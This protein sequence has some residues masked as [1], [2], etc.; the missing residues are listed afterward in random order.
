MLTFQSRGPTLCDGL[1]RREW[2]RIGGLSA[3]G[4]GLPQLQQARAASDTSL[5]SQK[6]VPSF[7]KAKSCIVLFLLGGPPQHETW[8]P[9]PDAPL[10]IRGDLKPIASATPGLQVGELMPLTSKLTNHIAVLRATATDD[11][12]HSSSGYAFPQKPR[13]R[14]S[15]CTQRLAQH[16][17]GGK[18]PEGRSRQPTWLHPLARGDLEYRKNCLAWPKCG[19]AG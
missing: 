12:A 7:G 4:I 10:E 15:R 6:L 3:F 1:S 9:K 13:E 14:S 19:L 11:N 16:G 2:L 17:C 8:D 5:L 18:A